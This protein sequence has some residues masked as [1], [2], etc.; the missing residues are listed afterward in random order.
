MMIV[1]RGARVLIK[2]LK[3]DNKTSGGIY[4]PDTSAKDQPTIGE[5]I[6]LGSEKVADLKIGDQVVYS[7]FSGTEIKDG[8]DNHL[9]ID[10]KDVLGIIS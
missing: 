3:I 4:L 1:P 7:K 9:L 2:T 6:A 10:E 8:E 5:V